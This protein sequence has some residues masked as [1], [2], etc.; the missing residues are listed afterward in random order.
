MQVTWGA[1]NSAWESQ[2]TFPDS[3]VILIEKAGKR[4]QFF[5]KSRFCSFSKV[6]KA[7]ISK[8]VFDNCQSSHFN[9]GTLSKEK[10]EKLCRQKERKDETQMENHCLTSKTNIAVLCFWVKAVMWDSNMPILQG[11]SKK[12]GE[13]V[14]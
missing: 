10:V 1:D 6:E 3:Q 11:L 12:Y 2:T 9:L 8:L 5:S 7:A 14:L 13:N 4:W